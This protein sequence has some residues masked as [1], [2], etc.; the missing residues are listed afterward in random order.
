MGG[1]AANDLKRICALVKGVAAYEAAFPLIGA[2]Q[3]GDSDLA[4]SLTF[5][6]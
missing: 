1:F 4:V 5:S 6:A 3:V 2:K